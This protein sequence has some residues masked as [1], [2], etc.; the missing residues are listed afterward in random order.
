MNKDFCNLFISL[1]V[2]FFVFFSFFHT[3]D[4]VPAIGFIDCVCG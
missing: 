3:Y 2:L 1:V 4:L